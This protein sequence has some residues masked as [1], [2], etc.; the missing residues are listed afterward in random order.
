VPVSAFSGQAGIEN[1]T[2]LQG[3]DTTPG[4]A[5][6]SADT[7]LIYATFWIEMLSHATTPQFLELQY[8]QMVVLDFAI[9]T[10]LNPAGGTPLSGNLVELG[11]PTSRWAPS[12]SPSDD[13]SS[14]SHRG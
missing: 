10:V 2:F 11:W 9:F 14:D 3:G 4:A 5:G 12:G 8:A 6:P 13:G 1:I 7:A